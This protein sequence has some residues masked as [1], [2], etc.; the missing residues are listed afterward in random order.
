MIEVDTEAVAVV[1]EI[2]E[3]EAEETSEVEAEVT[4]E[5]VVGVSGVVVVVS[6]AEIVVAVVDS[7]AEIPM[8]AEE[9]AEEEWMTVGI[10]LVMDPEAAL[11]VTETLG[12]HQEMEEETMGAGLVAMVTNIQQGVMT[13][14]QVMIDEIAMELHQGTATEVD[15]LVTPMAAGTMAEA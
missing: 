9:E 1:E 8:T 13:H 7:V 11:T 3:E 14:D 2:S 15:H 10:G 6:T 4:S 5:E 12:A